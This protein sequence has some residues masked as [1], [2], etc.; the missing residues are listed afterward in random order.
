MSLDSGAKVVFG[1]LTNMVAVF[2]TWSLIHYWGI[3]LSNFQG[4]SI[5]FDPKNTELS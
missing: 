3:L 4:G 2:G 1:Y 5:S